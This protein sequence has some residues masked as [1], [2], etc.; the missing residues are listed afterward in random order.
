MSKIKISPPSILHLYGD[1][2][3]TETPPHLTEDAY[4]S[5]LGPLIWGCFGDAMV[6]QFLIPNKSI[7]RFPIL[8]RSYLPLALTDSSP[9]PETNDGHLNSNPLRIPA[10]IHSQKS[11]NLV[12]YPTVYRFRILGDRI[13]PHLWF[14]AYTTASPPRATLICPSLSVLHHLLRIVMFMN[15]FL[16]G[17]GFL[18]VFMVPWLPLFMLFDHYNL[19]K[20]DQDYNR[21]YFFFDLRAVSFGTVYKGYIDENVRVGLKSLPV[22][23]KVL[24]KEGLQ[25]HI[26]WLTEVNFLGQLRHPNLVKLI[27]YC[28][29]DDHRLLV[30][31][32]MFRGSLENHLFRKTSA[33]LSWPTRMMIAFGAAKGLAF[34]HNAE[35]PFIQLHLEPASSN[36]LPGNA[37]GSITQKLRVTNSQRGKKSVV[38]RIR[39]SYKVSQ[40]TKEGFERARDGLTEA[41]ALSESICIAEVAAELPEDLE[42]LRPPDLPS[43]LLD[44]LTEL[45]VA[46]FMWLDYDNPTKP[47]YLY[48]NSS[49]TQND[50]METVGSETEAYAIADIMAYCKSEVYTVN[51]GMAF[52]TMYD[53]DYKSPNRSGQNFKSGEDMVEMLK[54]QWKDSYGI[55]GRIQS[56]LNSKFS[57]FL[58]ISSIRRQTYF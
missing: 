54:K 28:C 26:E 9:F 57:T 30:Y 3:S 58:C 35:R 24:N 43:L 34:L 18:K 47:I 33:P 50:K 53:L 7:S 31:E 36:T 29:E 49:G 10:L 37:S 42:V 13:V 40:Y 48:I 44:A 55:G 38:M 6:S 46:Q 21:C 51:C 41:A 16:C 8:S 52:G 19:S 32:F 25:G 56:Q 15:G 45:L 22:A 12:V 1:Q 4:E 2:G 5:P 14:V 39:I 23:V 27:G 11:E 17:F 20:K